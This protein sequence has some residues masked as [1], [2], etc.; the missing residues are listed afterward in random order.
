MTESIS[1]SSIPPTALPFRN[2][3]PITTLPFRSI[4]HSVPLPR[5]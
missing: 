2:I 5:A 3:A 1:G 4:G